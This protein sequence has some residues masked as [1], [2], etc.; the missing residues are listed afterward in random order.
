MVEGIQNAFTEKKHWLSSLSWCQYSLLH[1]SPSVNFRFPQSSRQQEVTGQGKWLF[2][3]KLHWSTGLHL[4]A[5]SYCCSNGPR[6]HL[7]S[8][9][10][11]LDCHS[12]RMSADL[13]WP[14]PSC[15]TEDTGPPLLGPPAC[16]WLLSPQARLYDLSETCPGL[17]SLPSPLCSS[18]AITDMYLNSLDLW[19]KV[20]TNP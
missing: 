3:M 5:I 14:N 20:S 13:L 6:P 4:L 8:V 10:D 1:S 7:A 16:C 17:S 11:R 15:K 19:L 18:S 9:P 2:L 12:P